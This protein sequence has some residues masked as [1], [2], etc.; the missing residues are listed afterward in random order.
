MTKPNSAD[1]HV[2]SILSCHDNTID[3]RPGSNAAFVVIDE[4]AWDAEHILAE[5]RDRFPDCWQRLR[6]VQAPREEK[7]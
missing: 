5:M 6:D 2:I 3:K 1:H 7:P 4:A